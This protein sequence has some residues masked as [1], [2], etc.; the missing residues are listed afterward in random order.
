[1]A[2][3]AP[4]RLVRDHAV[5][6]GARARAWSTLVVAAGLGA[7][8][9]AS[10]WITDEPASAGR[11]TMLVLLGLACCSVAVV[12][13][14][15]QL[16]PRDPGA[17]VALL[18]DS[19]IEVRLRPHQPLA[20]LVLGLTWSALLAA[21]VVLG[22]SGALLL[23]PVLLLFLSLV[24]DSARTLVRRPRLRYDATGI[25]LR[26]WQ[27]DAAIAWDDVVDVGLVAPDR[28]RPQVRIEGRAGAASYQRTSRRLVLTLEPR[29]D[30]ELVD[31]PLLAL[32]DPGRLLTHLDAVRRD[33]E[34]DRARWLDAEAVRYLTGDDAGL[35][36]GGRRP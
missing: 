15:A 28:R 22:G 26:G 20:V 33:A 4:T 21:G 3:L 8:L 13:W 5:D 29:P 12:V 10:P 14:L 7:L 36:P 16:A 31:V 32:D 25:Q 1:M 9:V 27:S 11:S 34:Q 23:L 30:R 19:A 24:P 17:R 18:A 35:R 2:H 6:R